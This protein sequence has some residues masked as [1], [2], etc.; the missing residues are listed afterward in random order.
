MIYLRSVLMLQVFNIGFYYNVVCF[1]M[2]QFHDS[3]LVF[4]IYTS[5]VESTYV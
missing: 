1:F 3:T 5:P 4:R 2:N